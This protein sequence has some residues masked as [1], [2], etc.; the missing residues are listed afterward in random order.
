MRAAAQAIADLGYGNV[1]VS[2]IAERAQM[3]PGHVTYYFPSKNE[4]LLLA[5]RRSEEELIETSRARLAAI[6]DPFERLRQLISLSAANGAQDEGWALW[7]NVWA[8]G[9]LDDTVSVEH[10]RLESR[11]FELLIEVIEYGRDRGAFPVDD[12]ADVAEM[13]SAL[14]DGLS[15]QVT[16]G[17]ERVDRDRALRL[18][19]VGAARILG[20]NP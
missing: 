11:W 2:D 12:V 18:C 1:R 15:I 6:E 3:T 8:N 16:V 14:I 17:S 7:L 9:M 5:I 10:N 13:I 19:E 4:L 20:V